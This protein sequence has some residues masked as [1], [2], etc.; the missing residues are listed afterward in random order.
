MDVREATFLI[1]GAGAVGSYVAARLHEKGADVTLLTRRAELVTLRGLRLA[2]PLGR[3]RHPVPAIVTTTGRPPV[4]VVLLCCRANVLT[5]AVSEAIAVCGPHTIVVSLADGGPHRETLER[6]LP[7]TRVIEGMFEARLR[8]DADG[9]VSH[10]LPEARITIG[11]RGPDDI[12]AAMIARALNGRGLVAAT[13]DNMDSL[14]WA[15]TIY[16]A[17]GIG[18]A[19]LTGRP[20]RDALRFLP[21]KSHFLDLM[22]D[23]RE[24]AAANGVTVDRRQTWAYRHAPFLEA[25]PVSAPARS[26]DPGG[27]GLEALHIL[28]RMARQTHERSAFMTALEAATERD[29]SEAPH[30]A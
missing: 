14:V 10:R 2:S 21:G 11:T 15:R 23:G 17:A 6:L 28:A 22:A 19:A 4:D 16:L 26:T 20:F 24:I 3:F 18:A 30:V 12:V 13:S 9:I 5:E 1:V 8:L 7:Q 27:A 25:S 29:C